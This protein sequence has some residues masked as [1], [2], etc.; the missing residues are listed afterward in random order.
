MNRSGSTVIFRANPK[1]LDVV[2]TNALGEPSNSTVVISDGDV[3][4]RTH[5]ALWCIGGK[6]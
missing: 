5:A 3:F 1:Q 2:A 4:L 6:R